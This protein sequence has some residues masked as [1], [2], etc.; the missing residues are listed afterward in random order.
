MKRASTILLVPFLWPQSEV[1]NIPDTPATLSKATRRSPCESATCLAVTTSHKGCESY[2]QRQ[3]D[4]EA[5]QE[6]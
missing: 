4:G 1:L 2:G 5:T 6:Q 3:N